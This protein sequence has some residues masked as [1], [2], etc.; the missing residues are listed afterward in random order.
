MPSATRSTKP[1]AYPP[2]IAGLKAMQDVANIAPGACSVN[3]GFYFLF[4]TNYIPLGG[5]FQATLVFSDNTNQ[6]QTISVPVKLA[7]NNEYVIRHSFTAALGQKLPVWA[8]LT[9]TDQPAMTA[10]SQ[11]WKTALN[12]R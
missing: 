3:V 6:V 9:V 7:G 8:Q 4:Q 12:C 11:Y 2:L 10:S 5:T 1:I